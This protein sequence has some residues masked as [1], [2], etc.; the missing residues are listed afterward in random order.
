MLIRGVV[1]ILCMLVSGLLYAEGLDEVSKHKFSGKV[2]LGGLQ[3]TGNT[4]STTIDGQL[5][6]EHEYQQWLTIVS[7]AGK[8]TTDDGVLS[9]DNY[10]AE[11]KEVY[12]LPWQTY[13]FVELNYREDVFSGIYSEVTKLAGLGYHFFADKADYGIAFELGYGTRDTKKVAKTKVDHDPGTHIAIFAEYLWTEDDKM[14]LNITVEAGN[15][16][17]FIKKELLWEHHLFDAFTLDF[18][19]EVITLT[20][21]PAGKL[22]VDTD[23]SVQLGYSF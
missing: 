22:G 17:E 23:L 15:D 9:S 8:Q 11:L 3:T 20:K 6:L 12:Q 16:D 14:N 4:E 10:N 19:Y 5:E 2:D 1:F 7:F 21:P 18:S 13:V